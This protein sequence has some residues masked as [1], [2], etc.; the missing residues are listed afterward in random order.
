MEEKRRHKRLELTVSLQL[1]YLNEQS[2]KDSREVVIEVSDISSNG[3]GFFSHEKLDTDGFYNTQ[4]VIWTKEVIPCVIH[5]VR[6]T[7]EEGRYHY[8]GI[9]VGM[10]EIDQ[11]KIDIYQMIEELEQER[12][13]KSGAADM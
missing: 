8:G 9:F 5:V 4:M 2:E 7:A 12:A 11:R 13:Q 1:E 10:N 6:E 3:I